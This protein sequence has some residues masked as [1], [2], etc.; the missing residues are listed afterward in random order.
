MTTRWTVVTLL[1]NE[2]EAGL[3]E[4]TLVELGLPFR[5][6]SYHDSAYDGVYQTQRGWGQLLAP[7]S[8]CERVRQVVEDLRRS[9]D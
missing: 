2:L 7:E 6:R 1:E 9:V 5:L 4:A 3:V 8:E